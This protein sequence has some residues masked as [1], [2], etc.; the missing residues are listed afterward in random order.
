MLI[1]KMFFCSALLLGL[2]SHD[3]RDF[4]PGILNEIQHLLTPGGH[5]LSTSCLA[6]LA[7]L[8]GESAASSVSQVRLHGDDWKIPL[9]ASVGLQGV[10]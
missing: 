4:D 7:S 1:G 6:R 10:Q 2:H 3:S 5:R 9:W 8:N